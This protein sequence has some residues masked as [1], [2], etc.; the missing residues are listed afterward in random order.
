MAL[1]FI[2]VDSF[3]TYIALSTDIV[4]GK[5]VGA[6]LVGKT[7]FTTDDANWYIIKK[8]L[9]LTAFDLPVTL[10]GDINIA[11]VNQGLGGISPWLV[12]LASKYAELQV[13]GTKF[14]QIVAD[15]FHYHVHNGTLWSASYLQTGIAQGA[16][17]NIGITTGANECHFAANYVSSGDARIDYY[18][19]P[20]F[21]GGSS[22]ELLNHEYEI[23]TPPETVMVSNPTVTGV[24]TLKRSLYIPGGS[25][26]NR[27]GGYSPF[28][29]EYII[30]ANSTL[31]ILYTNLDGTNSIYNMT[32]DFYEV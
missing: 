25:G 16:T 1:Q 22:I 6:S 20:V 19:S 2:S 10:V 12:T 5:I 28:S 32:A 13:N 7:I 26:G 17:V 31:R 15:E 27:Q 30:P 14:A 24:G 4:D 11:E 18:L 9:N 23:T 3:P 8:D 21:T 29:R